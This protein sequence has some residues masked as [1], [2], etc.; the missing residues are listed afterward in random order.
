[1]LERR[2]RWRLTYLGQPIQARVLA[3]T[4]EEYGARVTWEPP[5]ERRD[6]TGNVGVDYVALDVTAFQD[7]VQYAV[8][9]FKQRLPGADVEV[10]EAEGKSA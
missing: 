7:E 3:L 8:S 4:L 10:E 9:K 5:Q 2:V 1:M 6:L